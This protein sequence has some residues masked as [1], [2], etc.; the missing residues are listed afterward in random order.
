LLK[1][2]K[3]GL[4]GAFPVGRPDGSFPSRYDLFM[5]A[6]HETFHT[7]PPTKTTSH[8]SLSKSVKM[9]NLCIKETG[10]AVYPMQGGC[11][12]LYNT[13]DQDNDALPLLEHVESRCTDEESLDFGVATP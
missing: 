4:K 6:E 9:M 2:E 1:I 5:N 7:K 13:K 10:R 11:K 12:N 3:M 8:L